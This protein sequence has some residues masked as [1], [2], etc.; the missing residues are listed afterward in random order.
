LRHSH[1][2]LPGYR[3]TIFNSD[4]RVGLTVNSI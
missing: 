3:T 2:S 4:F 1:A